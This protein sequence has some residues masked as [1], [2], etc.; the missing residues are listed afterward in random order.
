M[1]NIEAFKEI[2]KKVDEIHYNLEQAL[3]CDPE[4]L[5]AGALYDITNICEEQLKNEGEKNET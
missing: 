1:T 3:P 5:G 4:E 2:Q